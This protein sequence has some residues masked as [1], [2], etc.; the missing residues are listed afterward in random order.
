MKVVKKHMTTRLYSI[1][2]VAIAAF[3]LSSA[4]A[5]DKT[6]YKWTDAEGEIHYSE[7]KPVG[8]AAEAFKV[9]G[10]KPAG[11]NSSVASSTAE[12]A[13]PNPDTQEEIDPEAL[14]DPE[15][16]KIATKNLETLNN[17]ARIR[18]K[19]P[20]TDEFRYLNQEEISEKKQEAQTAMGE[21]C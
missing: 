7:R 19:D 16:C 17:N 11:P 14:K 5:A 6:L 12:E 2:F 21:S 9:S 8:V 10:G 1:F 20:G 18:M 3:W 13:V 15:R 4:Q